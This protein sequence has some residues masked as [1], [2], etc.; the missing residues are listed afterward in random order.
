MLAKLRCPRL[1][2]SRRWWDI[3]LPTTDRG[4]KDGERSHR[5]SRFLTHK[6]PPTVS[7]DS[8]EA[9]GI[10]VHFGPL[11]STDINYRA[12]LSRPVLE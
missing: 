2:D 1:R 11:E 8:I 4:K 10:H 7:F 9:S 5:F 3:T 6:F 12:V